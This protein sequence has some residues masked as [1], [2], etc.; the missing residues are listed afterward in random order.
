MVRAIGALTI[1]GLFALGTD[2]PHAAQGSTIRFTDV[3]G[4]T[5][6]ASFLNIS[7]TPSKDFIVE[8][9][10][11]GVA[12]F[13]YDNDRD[14]DVLIVNGSTLDREGDGSSN[15]CAVSQRRRAVH[16]RHGRSRPHRRGWGRGVCV[17]DYDNDGFE[18]VYIT[19]YGPNVLWRN[20][21][22]RSFVAT[23]Q[24]R[25]PR[26]S[27]GCA[28]GDYDRD[29]DV[30]LYVANYVRFVPTRCRRAAS[31]HL[32][33]REHRRVLRPASVCRASPTRCTATGERHVHRRDEGH[34]TP[35]SP[36][37]TASV[38]CSAIST[39]TAG[40]TFTSRTTRH[41]ICSSATGATG[42]S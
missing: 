17:A 8:S 29:G 2:P 34:A 25:D 20:I 27:T 36:A 42:R 7:G 38:S 33:L 24:A 32:P 39:T 11:N 13:D 9:I 28:F 12:F 4:S 6:L 23:T 31:G 1:V 5:G 37:T 30:D 10:G 19:A 3:S 41:R 14:L 21:D 26:W 35:W 16:R 18:D 40:R 22:G 15:G